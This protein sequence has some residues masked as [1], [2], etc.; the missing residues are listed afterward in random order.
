MPYGNSLFNEFEFLPANIS[1]T[2]CT[3]FPLVSG[4]TII[5]NMVPTRQTAANIQ[6]VQAA[7]KTSIIEL[8][9]NVIKV[10]VIKLEVAV[11]VAPKLFTSGSSSSPD[12]NQGIGPI[13]QAQLTMKNT[14]EHNGNQVKASVFI[15]LSSIQKQN[16]KASRLN[17]MH[18]ID[19]S[20]KI[21]RPVRS[22]RKLEAKLAN[23]WVP[24]RTMV[25]I[26]GDEA[27][28]SSKIIF[29]KK[30]TALTPENC[31]TI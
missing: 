15:L 4:T 11:T 16:P 18:S 12:I 28:A 6:N 27:L 30:I 8:K 10:S 2:S 29:E 5:M 22:M 7:L 3:D 9:K 17:P 14:I 25:Q 23:D 26:I 31:W 13:P 20:S 1:C 21:L 24:P 19:V